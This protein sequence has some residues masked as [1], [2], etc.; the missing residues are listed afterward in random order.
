MARALLGVWPLSAGTVRW[1]DRAL[2]DWS[3]ES[4]GRCVGYL[5]QDVELFAGTIAENICRLTKVDADRVVEAAR[6]A[7][8]H[9]VVL[10]LPRGYDTP[11][12][13]AGQ[14]LSGGQRQRLGLARAVYGRPSLVVLDEPNANLDEAGEVALLHC[15]DRLRSEGV[16]ILIISHRPGVRSAADRVVHLVAGRIESITETPR[17]AGPQAGAVPPLNKPA[18]VAA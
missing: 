16:A 10:R 18:V 8:L 6:K 17:P 15:V 11:V 1:G 4:R 14:L 7:D 2:T 12:G 3:A 9:E 13:E 5:P